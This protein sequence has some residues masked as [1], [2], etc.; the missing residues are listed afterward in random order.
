MS[1]RSFDQPYDSH[2]AF[3][4]D[5]YGHAL[6]DVR[7]AGSKGAV[8]M[9]AELGAGDW[10]DAPVPELLVTMLVRHNP[11]VTIDL[12]AGRF[13][14]AT[15]VCRDFVVTPPHTP[16]TILID[17]PNTV[18]FVAVPYVVLLGLADD[19]NGLPAD[20]DFG[21]LHA[22]MLRDRD[23]AAL[24][25]RLWSEAQDGSPHGAL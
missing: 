25:D 11:G 15:M 1:A 17:G 6:R 14:E 2:A 21:T 4:Q 18:C 16:T 20:G 10:S 24:L 8:M 13:R 5:V 23:T 7:P 3:Y 19:G 9:T 12:G 22:G